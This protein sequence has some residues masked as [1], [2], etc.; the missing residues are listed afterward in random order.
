MCTYC[1]MKENNKRNNER[2]TRANGVCFNGACMIRCWSGWFNF[3]QI[4]KE[5]KGKLVY[6]TFTFAD[7]YFFKPNVT[8]THI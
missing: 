8:E 3:C 1:Y 7:S 6:R 2:Q 4:R 5:K